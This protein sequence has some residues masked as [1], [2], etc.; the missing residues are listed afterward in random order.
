MEE[1]DSYEIKVYYTDINN[2]V[3]TDCDASEDNGDLDSVVCDCDIPNRECTVTAVPEDENFNGTTRFS[4]RLND[5]ENSEFQEVLLVVTPVDDAPEV[6]VGDFDPAN[7]TEDSGVNQITF[8]YNDAEGDFANGCVVSEGSSDGGDSF[9]KA[10][11]LECRCVEAG[12]C[13]F[14][15]KTQKNFNGNLVVTL[16]VQS[17]GLRSEAVEKT[18][19]VDNADDDPYF[20]I[21][22]DHEMCGNDP[23]SS[24]QCIGVTDP[25]FNEGQLNNINAT[26]DSSHPLIY[27]NQDTGECFR[28]IKDGGRNIAFLGSF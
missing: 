24:Q 12:L 8:Q 28:A 17:N 16:E 1:S 3:A 5:G 2:D 15:V 21:F 23:N 20:C 19:I 7:I 13:Y 4:Y 25:A 6:T 10:E 22:S 9:D 11:I 18:L 27:L 14:N 26:F